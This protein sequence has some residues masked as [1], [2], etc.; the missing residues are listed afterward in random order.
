MLVATKIINVPRPQQLDLVATNT[1]LLEYKRLTD[2]D[3]HTGVALLT[4]MRNTPAVP[5]LGNPNRPKRLQTMLD[6]TFRAHCRQNKPDGVFDIE[7]QTAQ[8][9]SIKFRVY[10]D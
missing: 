7:I 10:R 5:A 3:P 4:H 6:H 9:P 8:H 1:H 2:R